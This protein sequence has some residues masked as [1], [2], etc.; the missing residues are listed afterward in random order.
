MH[1]Y[2]FFMLT[3]EKFPVTAAALVLYVEIKIHPGRVST[4]D[5]HLNFIGGEWWMS[6][7][8]IVRA[9]VLVV[10]VQTVAVKVLK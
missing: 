2:L 1:F 10:N 4:D 8:L 6:W 7:K 9:N 5:D 3:P